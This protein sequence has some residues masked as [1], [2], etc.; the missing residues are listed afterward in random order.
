MRARVPLSRAASFPVT[1]GVALL[2]IAA[3][4][5]YWLGRDVTPM[6]M[7]ERAFFAQP[8]RLLTSALLHADVVHLAF[9]VYWLWVFGTLLETELGAARL[10]GLMVTFAVLSGAGQ[11]ATGN[12][13]IGLS[14]IG[15]GLWGFL[16][17]A[18]RRDTRFADAMDGKTMQLFGAWF[19]LCIVLTWAKVW[20]IA[21]VAHGVGAVAG[22]LASVAL[23]GAASKPRQLPKAAG[24]LGLSVLL[25]VCLLFATS[26]RPSVNRDANAGLEVGARAYEALTAQR[27]NEAIVLYERALK[28]SPDEPTLWFNLGIA[29]QREQRLGDAR[30]AYQHAAQLK[31]GDAMY[32]ETAEMIPAG[33]R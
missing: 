8:W 29:Y 1:V 4:A 15:Y 27:N 18:Q 13:G 26:L 5:F 12:G 30:G 16:C 24:W 9:N 32:R 17:G 33:V 22:L 6:L 11:F 2:A 28:L 19:V 10:V 3:T 23:T 14:G 25:V 20:Q 21:N 31:P 7:Q